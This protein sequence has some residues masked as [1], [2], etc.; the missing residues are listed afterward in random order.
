MQSWIKVCDLDK[1]LSEEFNCE[2]KNAINPRCLNDID[3]KIFYNIGIY[4]VKKMVNTYRGK[5]QDA[6]NEAFH[7]YNEFVIAYGPSKN[8]ELK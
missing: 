6:L 7:N 5:A 4:F 2:I 3:T 1:I 8:T